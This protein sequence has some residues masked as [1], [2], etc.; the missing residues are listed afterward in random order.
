MGGGDGEHGNV[1]SGGGGIAKVTE[2]QKGTINLSPM[3]T[4]TE[5]HTGSGCLVRAAGALRLACGSRCMLE[6]LEQHVKPSIDGLAALFVFELLRSYSPTQTPR[7]VLG[8]VLE[9]QVCCF[10]NLLDCSSRGSCKGAEDRGVEW[11]IGKD[12]CVRVLCVQYGSVLKENDSEPDKQVEEMLESNIL[13]VP[14]VMLSSD[15]GFKLSLQPRKELQQKYGGRLC[16]WM[17]R[18]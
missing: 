13:R 9:G 14:M 6:F 8:A 2:I 1:T 18:N 4:G 12:V 5:L 3:T 16:R 7:K 17:I 15:E 11:C 10:L